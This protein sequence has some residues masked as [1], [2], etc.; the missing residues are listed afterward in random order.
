LVLFLLAGSLIG[1]RLAF[2]RVASGVRA[3]DFGETVERP[4]GDAGAIVVQRLVSVRLTGC[5]R[6]SGRIGRLP[7]SRNDGRMLEQTG[8][9]S[10]IRRQGRTGPQH[11]DER[12]D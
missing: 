12:E 7:W 1:R 8:G 5:V 10:V 2:P 4:G 11:G 6:G 9:I 3:L